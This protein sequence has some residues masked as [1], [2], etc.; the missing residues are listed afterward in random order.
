MAFSP[1][2]AAQ[3]E[4][5]EP[6]DPLLLYTTRGCFHN[7]TRDRG[8]IVGELTVASAP[9]PLARPLV[10]AGRTFTV[11]CRLE[12]VSLAPRGV[13]VDLAPLVD[14]LQTFPDPSSWSARMRRPLV[15]L[16]AA[17]ADRLRTLL[18]PRLASGLDSAI[19]TYVTALPVERAA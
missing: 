4:V 3:A 12:L 9:R 15:P 7:P 19:E 16:T 8:Q 5:L 13:G 11:G 2:R 18:Q 6:G 1:R 10:L 17:D 14:R